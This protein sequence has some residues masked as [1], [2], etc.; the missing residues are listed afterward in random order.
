[1]PA[2][3]HV[4]VDALELT[5]RPLNRPPKDPQALISALQRALP[6]EYFDPDGA[7]LDTTYLDPSLRIVCFLGMRFAGV[8]HVY[9][10]ILP[11]GASPPSAVD[12]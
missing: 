8:R 1:M 5:P 9:S 12:P 7:V 11:P 2:R 6:K 4:A 10:R 3:S